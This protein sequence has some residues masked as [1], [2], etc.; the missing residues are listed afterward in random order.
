MC[1]DTSLGAPVQNIVD[2]LHDLAAVDPDTNETLFTKQFKVS[3]V[4]LK[5]YIILILQMLDSDVLQEK[6]FTYTVATA[7]KNVARNRY[8]SHLAGWM[9]WL[10]C[11]TYPKFLFL[12]HSRSKFCI[13]SDHR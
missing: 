2:R 8:Q 10:T 13:P 9:T 11:N 5:A 6:K 1:G 3:L 12:F 7:P 4:I